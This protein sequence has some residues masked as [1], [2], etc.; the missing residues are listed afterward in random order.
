MTSA[1]MFKIQANIEMVVKELSFES[2]YYTEFVICYKIKP[3]S[4]HHGNVCLY[5]LILLF[6]IIITL[7]SKREY[8]RMDFMEKFMMACM[9]TD[10]W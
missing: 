9:M 1:E 6:A 2:K 4:N 8:G 7:V 5:I 3:T 10:R